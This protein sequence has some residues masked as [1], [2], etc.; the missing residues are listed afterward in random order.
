ME[1]KEV[2]FAAC[3]RY[4]VPAIAAMGRKETI[5]FIACMGVLC[6]LVAELFSKK[7]V[8]YTHLAAPDCAGGDGPQ[9]SAQCPALVRE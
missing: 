4:G 5:A 1:S 2:L 3:E 9:E 6:A 8:S 7:A